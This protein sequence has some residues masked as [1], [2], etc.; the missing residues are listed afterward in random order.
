MMRPTSPNAMYAI[1][2]RDARASRNQY[3]MIA[4]TTTPIH[5]YASMTS[6]T[7]PSSTASHSAV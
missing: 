4:P 2:C 7:A 1:E 5:T 3:F 6:A